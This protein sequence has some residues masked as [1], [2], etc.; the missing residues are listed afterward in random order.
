M[1][2][3][4]T[5]LISSRLEEDIEA[6]DSEDSWSPKN[7]PTAQMDP[8]ATSCCDSDVETMNRILYDKYFGENYSR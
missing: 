1:N 5:D 2:F 8:R 7:R 6:D 4:M 3:P